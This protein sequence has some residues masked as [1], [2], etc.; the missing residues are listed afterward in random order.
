MALLHVVLALTYDRRV[1]STLPTLLHF[2]SR[3]YVESKAVPQNA[4]SSLHLVQD[5]CAF[6]CACESLGPALQSVAK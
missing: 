4:K 3:F 2:T 1:S 5:E 6:E